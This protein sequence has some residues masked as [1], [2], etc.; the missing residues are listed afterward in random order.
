M[1]ISFI[2]S[3]INYIVLI[4]AIIINH[5]PAIIKYRNK[6]APIIPTIKGKSTKGKSAI[7]LFYFYFNKVKQKS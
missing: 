3:H 5:D 2:A 1:K 7:F 6:I 4:I